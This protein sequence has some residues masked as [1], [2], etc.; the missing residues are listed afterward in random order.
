MATF[1]IYF[2]WGH[3]FHKR[4]NTRLQDYNTLLKCTSIGV[5]STEVTEAVASLKNYFSADKMF[6]AS[7]RPARYN[8]I[9]VPMLS[10]K[11]RESLDITEYWVCNDK[12]QILHNK[13][14][15]ILINIKITM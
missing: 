6:M 15:F 9:F 5:A 3:L 13:M 11:M 7:S 8:I 1:Q 2:V 12:Q 10:I 4:F 14:Y